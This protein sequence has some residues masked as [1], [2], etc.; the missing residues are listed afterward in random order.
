MTL[1]SVIAEELGLLGTSLVLLI[2]LV[3]FGDY[4]IGLEIR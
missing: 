3:L 2:Y 1:F 4:Y